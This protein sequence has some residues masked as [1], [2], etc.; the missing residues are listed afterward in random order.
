MP[1]LPD[2]PELPDELNPQSALFQ[3]ICAALNSTPCDPCAVGY[4]EIM[5]GGFYFSDELPAFADEQPTRENAGIPIKA[6]W[7]LR[8]IM[9]YRAGLAGG[10]PRPEFEWIWNAVRK[11]APHWPGFR[12]ERASA[13]QQPLLDQCQWN[14]NEI[15][16]ALDNELEQEGDAT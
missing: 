15:I 2:D 1:F 3:R 13:M 8:F 14:T 4:P 11:H 12:P 5:S 6:C 16:R 7:L 10:K 9:A